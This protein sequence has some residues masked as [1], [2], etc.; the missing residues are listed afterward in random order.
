MGDGVFGIL[1]V[2]DEGGEFLVDLYGD[3]LVVGD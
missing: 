2:L 3:F 1:F